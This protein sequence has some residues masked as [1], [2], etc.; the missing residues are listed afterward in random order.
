MT[1]LDAGENVF[2][3]M[4]P[5]SG[6]HEGQ[7]CPVSLEEGEDGSLIVVKC[8]L[9]CLVHGKSDVPP[10][11][12]FPDKQGMKMSDG[13]VVPVGNSFFSP[14]GY[15]INTTLRM[16]GYTVNDVAEIYVFSK[17]ESTSVYSGGLKAAYIDSSCP[18]IGKDWWSQPFASSSIEK[19]VFKGRTY[20]EVEAMEYYPW[21]LQ[22]TSKIIAD[23][24][25]P[26]VARY[27]DGSV[28]ELDLS[29]TVQQNDVPK[30]NGEADLQSVE[31]RVPV[32]GLG[33]SVFKDCSQLTA[34]SMP[35]SMSDI[36]TWTFMNCSSLNSIEVPAAVA[37]LG[38]GVFYNCASLSS[39]TLPSQL[40]GIMN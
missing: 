5:L 38:N 24:N 2:N 8:I 12:W 17:L 35:S 25:L 7:F 27:T 23:P 16:L 14:T 32:S 4:C 15:D 18:S 26:T 13:T 19:V 30:K 31:L 22:D 39:V 29:G 34:V 11:P 33:D 9:K 40:S 20:A 3:V 36:G 6:E 28:L 37:R 10:A 1:A 21:G